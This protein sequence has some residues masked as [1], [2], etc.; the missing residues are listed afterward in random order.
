MATPTAR[1]PRPT[2]IEP[3]NEP[4]E[5]RSAGIPLT[6][7]ERS[8]IV[9]VFASVFAE[10]P[11]L[12]N[13]TDAARFASDLPWYEGRTGARWVVAERPRGP[14]V[15]FAFGFLGG[16]STEVHRA[17]SS[18]HGARAAALWLDGAFQVVEL[19]VL[20]SFRGQGIGGR[21]HDALLADL[22]AETAILFTD[23]AASDALRLY[24]ARGW[25]PLL[26]QYVSA[27]SGRPTLVM[28]RRMTAVP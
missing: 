4:V 7:H 3:M 1:A 20:P 5:V 22:E 16:F 14:L 23:A 9:S 27:I 13:A 19:A 2:A 26:D 21:L 24:R 8:E 15:G 11:W 12:E 18:A 28:G 17:I 25:I 10:P 6:P